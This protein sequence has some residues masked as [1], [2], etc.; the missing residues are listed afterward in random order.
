M[1]KQINNVKIKQVEDPSADTSTLGVYSNTPDKVFIDRKARGH[2]GL[3]LYRYFNLGAGDAAYIEQDYAR[4]ESLDRG[5]WGYIGIHAVAEITIHGTIQKVRTGGLWG[6]ESD[7]G[8][9]YLAQVGQEQ[10]AELWPIL[11]E[12]GFTEEQIKRAQDNVGGA[13]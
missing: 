11:A 8:A 2:M 7:S 3:N 4:A 6:I 13:E 10:L 9:D 1:S 5:E 12:M